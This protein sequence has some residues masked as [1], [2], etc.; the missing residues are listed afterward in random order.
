M[1]FVRAA[2]GD[3]LVDFIDGPAEPSGSSSTTSTPIAT[4]SIATSSTATCSTAT[5]STATSS[6]ATSSTATMVH[7]NMKETATKKRSFVPQITDLDLGLM[8]R[9]KTREDDNQL[10]GDLNKSKKSFFSTVENLEKERH[11]LIMKKNTLKCY[12]LVLKN[13]CLEKELALEESVIDEIRQQVS[14]QLINFPKYATEKL[15]DNK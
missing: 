4:S 10:Y 9:K 3:S 1:G 15:N 2:K 13:M 5:S 14:P 11:E 6:K 7:P 12:N 8:P